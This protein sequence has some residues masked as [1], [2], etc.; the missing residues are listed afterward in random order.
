MKNLYN[1]SLLIMILILSIRA[2]G[3]SGKKT[4][5]EERFVCNLTDTYYNDHVAPRVKKNIDSL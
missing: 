1:Y 2:N 4:A 5:D 3:Q